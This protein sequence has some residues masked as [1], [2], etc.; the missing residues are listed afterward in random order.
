MGR[1]PAPSGDDARVVAEF[2]E[3]AA[4]DLLPR[5]R[6]LEDDFYESDARHVV[7]DLK[8]M[9]DRAA[10]E[11]RVRHPEIPDGA[12]EALAWCYTYDYK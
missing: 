10:D 6:A 8:E 5:I 11:F 3:D 4:L 1:A 2:G 12:V 9:G 7:A